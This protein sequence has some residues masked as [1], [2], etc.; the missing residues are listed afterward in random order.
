MM[1]QIICTKLLITFVPMRRRQLL[2]YRSGVNTHNSIRLIC[3]TCW[4]TKKKQQLK[5]QHL[6]ALNFNSL[7]RQRATFLV[8]LT[9]P[10]LTQNWQFKTLT[11]IDLSSFDRLLKPKVRWNWKEIHLHNKKIQKKTFLF[12]ISRELR[13][14]VVTRGVS[15]VI[16]S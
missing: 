14:E 15:Y 3:H 11:I 12:S 13:F 16:T 2:W 4:Y 6:T 9:G 10:R 7:K 5:K 8:D 1:A